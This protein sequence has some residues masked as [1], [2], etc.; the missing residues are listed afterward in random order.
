MNDQTYRDY[1]IDELQGA[2]VDI[3]MNLYGIPYELMSGPEQKTCRVL[4]QLG[5]L[6]EEFDQPLDIN[7]SLAL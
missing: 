1:E 3:A 6:L 4:R 2:L 7:I 5:L